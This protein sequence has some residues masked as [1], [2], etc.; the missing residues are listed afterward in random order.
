[1]LDYPAEY[2]L[3]DYG[4]YAGIISTGLQRSSMPA[5]LANQVQSFNS[6][7][8]EINMSF[9]MD[10]ATYISWFL[11]VTEN[12]YRWFNM[13]VIS[14]AQ[15]TDILGV[16]QVRFMSDIAYQKRGDN[17]LTVNVTAELLPGQPPNP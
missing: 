16:R 13:E 11:W 3:P 15:P 2:P 9:S 14:G 12:A 17:W 4:A 1:M 5:A 6:P 10:N 7:R 8:T